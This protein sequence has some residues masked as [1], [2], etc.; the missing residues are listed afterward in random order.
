MP[1]TPDHGTDPGAISSAL[2][3][4]ARDVKETPG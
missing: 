3:A 1:G 4:R 2:E